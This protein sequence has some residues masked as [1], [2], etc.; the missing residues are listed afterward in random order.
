M[1]ERVFCYHYSEASITVLTRSLFTHFTT[2]LVHVSHS[3]KVTDDVNTDPK[4]PP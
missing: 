1:Q 2:T 4:N 3:L